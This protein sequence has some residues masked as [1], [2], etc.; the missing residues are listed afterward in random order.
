MTVASVPSASS[1][2]RAIPFPFTELETPPFEI[3]VDWTLAAV[4]TTDITGAPL[5]AG[6]YISCVAVDP[7]G[8]VWVSFSARPLAATA[9]VCPLAISS[10]QGSF[11]EP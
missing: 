11:T 3:R 6:L 8:T 4:T 2:L 9:S 7:A 10:G 1:K 5:P